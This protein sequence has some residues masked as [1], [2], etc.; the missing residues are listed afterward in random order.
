MYGFCRIIDLG[1]LHFYFWSKNYS[2]KV[3]T[4]LEKVVVLVTLSTAKLSLLFLDFSTIFNRFYKFQPIHSK[5]ERIF[6]RQALWNFSK[7][8]RPVPSVH[9]TPWKTMGLC[10]VVQGGKGGTAGRIPAR[11]AAGVT[12]K[13]AREGLRV[14]GTR[15]GGLLTAEGRP[16]IGCGGR[17]RWRPL[18]E[19]PRRAGGS[20]RTTSE[21]GGFC[22]ARGR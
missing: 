5:G 6:L 22:G 17:R 10:N 8:H 11:P 4:Y 13:V 16:A 21:H 3:Y 14:A 18:E 15:L 9:K 12:G 2:S 1:I 7:H 19:T 20:G